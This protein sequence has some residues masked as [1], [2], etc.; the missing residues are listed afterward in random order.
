M[1]EV[2][3]CPRGEG[4]LANKLF[5]VAAAIAIALRVGGRVVLCRSKWIPSGSSY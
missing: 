5:Q 4:G 3:I 1:G 2:V